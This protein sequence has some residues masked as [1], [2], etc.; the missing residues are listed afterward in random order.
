MCIH[1][2]FLYYL[3]LLLIREKEIHCYTD[4]QAYLLSMS[5]VARAY[6]IDN[7]IFNLCNPIRNTLQNCSTF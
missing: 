4:P 6:A 1:L 3:L 7:L 2:F 5:M